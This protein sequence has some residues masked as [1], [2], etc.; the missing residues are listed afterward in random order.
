MIDQ[1]IIKKQTDGSDLDLDQ[2]F[3]PLYARSWRQPQSISLRNF[4]SKIEVEINE[5]ALMKLNPDFVTSVPVE[6]FEETPEAPP[7][8]TVLKSYIAIDENYLYVWVGNR[9]K[10]TLLSEW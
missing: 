9:W 3:V 8:A 7:G 10:R 2:I 5:E 1:S 4:A 6:N